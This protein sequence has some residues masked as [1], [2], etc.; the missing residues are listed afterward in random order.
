MDEFINNSNQT[1]DIQDMIDGSS[2]DSSGKNF[3]V[4][5]HF[6]LGQPTITFN[7]SMRDLI[8]FT[9]VKNKTNVSIDPILGDE[10]VAQREE[11]RNHT[12]KLALYT[13]QGLVNSRIIEM[14]KNGDDIN[15]ELEKLI[16]ELN[17]PPYTSFPPLVATL[18]VNKSNNK[19]NIQ[20]TR[21]EDRAGNPTNCFIATLAPSNPIY[22]IDGQH[23]KRALEEVSNFLTKTLELNNYPKK[24][25]LEPAYHNKDYLSDYMLDFWSS[26]QNLA[27]T[28]CHVAVECHLKLDEF[29]EQQLFY[30]LNTHSRRVQVSDGWQFDHANKINQY[31]K[32]NLINKILPF[33]PSQKDQNN[34]NLDDGRLSRKDVN[35]LT[36]IMCIG[37]TISTKVTPK[38]LEERAK[39]LDI[40]WKSILE[41]PG[42]GKPNAKQNTVAGQTVVLKGLC[43]LGYELVHGHQNI[44]D[45]DGWKKLLNALQ[46]KQ[47]D[48]SHKNELWA[49]LFLASNERNKKFP[50][51]ENFVYINEDRVISYGNYDPKNEWVIFG[52]RSSFIQPRIGDLIRYNLNLNP[53]PSV[54]K[55]INKL[56]DQ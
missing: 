5:F 20:L 30:D 1:I 28:K 23:R 22:L 55:Q 53:R 54:T 7:M 29:C 50:G 8:Q 38:L 15:D 13:L 45:L 42:I 6:N 46:T 19:T 17:I 37:S 4:F 51:I 18:K 32:D 31:V 49:S 14:K 21:V 48:F 10:Y 16:S 27:F 47:I 35:N 24:G 40:F 26:I 12:K 2:P 44:R 9:K 43:Q 56:K 39:Y 3:Y 52:S 33:E 25:L 34:W 36:S 11:V 41:I